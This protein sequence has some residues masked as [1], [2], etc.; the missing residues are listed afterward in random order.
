M[1]STIDEEARERIQATTLDLC[2]TLVAL[3]QQG[4]T[5]LNESELRT[6][7]THYMRGIHLQNIE[8]QGWL[9]PK[10]MTLY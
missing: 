10:A 5:F 1:G 7:I 2:A 4:K 6:K 3:Q 8:R 9:P